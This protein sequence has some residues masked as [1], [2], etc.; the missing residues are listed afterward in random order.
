[1]YSRTSVLYRIIT[2]SLAEKKRLTMEK[3]IAITTV[4]C[5]IANIRNCNLN[6]YQK[7]YDFC[8]RSSS[9]CKRT[10]NKLSKLYDSVSYSTLTNL[11]DEFSNEARDNISKWAD[12]T[13]IHAGD[14]LDIRSKVRFESSG[15]SY[16]DVHLYYNML[17]KARICVDH[18]SDEPKPSFD[19]ATTDYSQFLPSKD[20]QETLLK[21]MEYQIL[22]VWKEVDPAM[23]DVVIEEPF[24][25]WNAEMKSKT[26][27]VCS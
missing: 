13:T 8:L 1:M 5:K 25:E 2:Q 26:E 23:E 7:M 18:L 20:E 22:S 14:N 12:E 3:E 27:K 16:H 6:A 21:L 11:L 9:T 24:N 17:Y 19:V 15:L 10:I 4:L